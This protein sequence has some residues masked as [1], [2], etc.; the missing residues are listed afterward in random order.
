VTLREFREKG[1]GRVYEQAFEEFQ[2][3]ALNGGNWLIFNRKM[4]FL[5]G[6]KQ[7]AHH[8]CVFSLLDKA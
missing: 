2:G 6:K 3:C 1:D 8:F 4:G 7:K 5:V